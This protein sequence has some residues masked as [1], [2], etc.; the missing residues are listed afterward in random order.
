LAAEAMGARLVV[1]WEVA[2]P[3]V[4]AEEARVGTAVSQAEGARAVVVMAWATVVEG[5][6]VAAM[7]VVMIVGTQLARMAERVAAWTVVLVAL[8]VT[9]VSVETVETMV[10]LGWMA[11][12]M[13]G[14]VRVSAVEVV[15]VLGRVRAAG[16]QVAVA[17]EEPVAEAVREAVVA[18]A[19]AVL[20]MVAAVNAE[21]AAVLLEVAGVGIV[22]DVLAWATA[23][24]VVVVATADGMV[25]G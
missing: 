12:V 19:R 16:V 4:Q 11:G 14:V 20:V 1:G 9:G 3:M 13:V 23:V 24:W 25:V 17:V 21:V 7:V 2:V 8:E 15:M 22:V 6:T 10:V 18:T 5:T